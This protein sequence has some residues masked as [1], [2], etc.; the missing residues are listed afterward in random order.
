MSR[1]FL[2][3]LGVAVACGLALPAFAQSPRALTLA[4]DEP[5]IRLDGRLDDAAWQR[6][7]VH[8]TFHQYLP[9]DRQPPPPGYRTTLQIVAERDALVFGLRAWDPAPGQL[10]ADPTRR[11]QVRRDQDFVAVYIDAV[12]DRRAAQFVRVSAAGVVGD[13]VYV[14]AGDSE[15]TA[16]D[17]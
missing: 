12:G 4:E 9:L 14:A 15:D 5:R 16:P 7:E 3:A 1:T 10:R 8:D 2:A 13:G 17:F 6:A 11:D